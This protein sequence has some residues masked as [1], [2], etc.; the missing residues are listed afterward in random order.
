MSHR[1]QVGMDWISGSDIRPFFTIRFRFRPK[2]WTAPDIVTEY[3]TCS[4]TA[5]EHECHKI[6]L[7][8]NHF[9]STNG[10]SNKHTSCIPLYNN[11][12]NQITDISTPQFIC[13]LQNLMH[14]VSMRSNAAVITLSGYGSG[15]G[16]G[17]IRRRITGVIWFRPDLKK[18]NPVHSDIDTFSPVSVIKSMKWKSNLFNNI[19]IYYNFL[20][21]A[22]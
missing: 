17:R 20:K 4:I 8:P 10:H 14:I 13:K 3:F 2:C 1:S 5:L 21:L 9:V 12:T 15:S 19:I 7:A 16:S 18:L 11:K 22:Y 6:W